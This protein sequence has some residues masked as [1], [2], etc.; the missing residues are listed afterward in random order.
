[1][2]G[3]WVVGGLFVIGQQLPY[4]Q[5]SPQ[6]SVIQQDPPSTSSNSSEQ[7]RSSQEYVNEPEPADSFT[8][9]RDQQ[10]SLSDFPKASCG[11]PLPSNSSDYP[12]TFYPV[13]VPYSDDNLAKVRSSLCQDTLKKR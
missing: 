9:E 8:L 12:I 3:I 6:L 5:P 13:F 11:D 2:I 7:E 4:T 10:F 1:V